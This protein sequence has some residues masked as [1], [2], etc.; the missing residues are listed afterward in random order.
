MKFSFLFTALLLFACGNNNSTASDEATI[1]TNKSAGEEKT[2]AASGEQGNGIVGEWQIKYI[3]TDE[4]GN[5]Q[6]DE[7]EIKKA[8]TQVNDYYNDYLKFS[9]DGSC[10]FSKAK[11][12]GKYKIEDESGQ[13]KLYIYDLYNN[14]VYNYTIFSVSKDELRLVA[15]GGENSFL[16]FKRI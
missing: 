1:A 6:L 14:E 7:N 2:T 8:R 5:R 16:V 10:L 13:S 9:A 15:Y 3:A 4:N 12:K 11:S